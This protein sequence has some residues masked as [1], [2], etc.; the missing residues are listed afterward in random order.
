MNEDKRNFITFIWDLDNEPTTQ[1][2]SLS[3]QENDS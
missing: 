2:E 3:A 1:T